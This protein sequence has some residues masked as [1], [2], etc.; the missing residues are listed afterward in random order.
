[1]NNINNNIYCKREYEHFK[2]KQSDQILINT[3]FNMLKYNSTKEI[4]YI[5]SNSNITHN[6]KLL[7]KLSDLRSNREADI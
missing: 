3:F 6:V 2:E 7:N 5:K 4:Q 1:M